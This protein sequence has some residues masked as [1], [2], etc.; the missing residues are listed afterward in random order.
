[1]NYPKKDLREYLT[2]QAIKV[3]E[4]YHDDNTNDKHVYDF[5]PSYDVDYPF[6]VVGEMFEKPYADS[7]RTVVQE[8]T[9]IHVF[10]YHEKIRETEDIVYYLTKAL[11]E[12]LE[13]AYY[14]WSILDGY[15]ADSLY[16]Y[17]DKKNEILSHV[18]IDMSFVNK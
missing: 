6:I 18:V 12:N 17:D 4:N 11:Y 8:D 5:V 9:I 14:G 16:E 1:M 10:N 13:Q 2:N 15:S 7:T 3:I